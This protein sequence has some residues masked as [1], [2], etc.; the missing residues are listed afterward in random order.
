MSFMVASVF[1]RSVMLSFTCVVL[2]IV[3]FVGYIVFALRRYNV[4]MHCD[5][6]FVLTSFWGA[7][8]GQL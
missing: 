8:T 5:T 4:F 3:C 7:S 1:A 2:S 6:V